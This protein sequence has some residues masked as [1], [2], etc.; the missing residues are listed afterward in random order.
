MRKLLILLSFLAACK[1]SNHSTADFPN[2]PKFDLQWGMDQ[3]HLPSNW[4]DGNA[5]RGIVIAILDTGVTKTKDLQGTKF[6]KGYNFVGNNENTEDGNQ[7]GTHVAATVAET[8]NNALGCV[9]VAYAAT[10]MPVKVLSDGGSGSTA[11]IAQAIRWATDRHVSIIGMSLGGSGRDEV[12]ANAMKYAHDHGVVITVA[13]GNSSRG[14]VSYPAKYPEAIAVAATRRDERTTF[15]SNWGK[16]IAIAAPGGDGDKKHPENGIL[17][18]TIVSG[19]DDY[20]FLNGTSMSQPFVAGVAA[21][22]MAEGI[23]DPDQVRKI[24]TETARVPKGMKTTDEFKLHYGA[25]I[26]DASA[27][28]KKA[29]SVGGKSSS[30]SIIT[31]IVIALIALGGLVFIRRKNKRTRG[32]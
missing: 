17:Q 12:M 25:G 23:T 20:Y 19:R 3:I 21:L 32:M 8:T 10:I 22:I 16:E 14:V 26:V 29:Q 13:S 2:D 24:L 6:V 5:G 4:K 31:Y 27:A 18:N 30:S 7:H 1:V 15:Y 9:G 28:V 11:G